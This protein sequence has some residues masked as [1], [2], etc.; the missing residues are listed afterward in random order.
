MTITNLKAGEKTVLTV[1]EGQAL[2][3]MGSAGA[4]GVVYWLDD[5]L[6]GGNSHQSWA[7]SAGALQVIGPFAGTNRFLITCAVGM[8]AAAVTSAVIGF[9]TIVVSNA[10]PSNS[11]GRPD[12]TV[13]IQ[14]A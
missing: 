1:Q 13:Y 11:D 2:N 8:I 14:T 9:P 4:Q 10:A 5:A 3:V 6:G 7:V 12:G